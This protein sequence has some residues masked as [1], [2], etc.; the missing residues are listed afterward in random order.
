MQEHQALAHIQKNCSSRICNLYKIVTSSPMVYN[1]EMYRNR[2]EISG[3]Q[4]NFS[5]NSQ[6]YLLL[7][8]IAVYCNLK[9]KDNLMANDKNQASILWRFI[10]QSES[11]ILCL[12]LLYVVQG[13]QQ[14]SKLLPYSNK[15]VKC[16]FDKK[17]QC[18]RMVDINKQQQIPCNILELR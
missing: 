13:S 9:I 4:Q 3:A 12:E 5:E 17:T 2:K 7:T 18:V 1:K 11:L 10:E 14:M 6:R 16:A 8:N 15:V